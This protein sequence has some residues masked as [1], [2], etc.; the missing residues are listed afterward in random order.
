MGQYPGMK[1][2][3]WYSI[4]VKKTFSIY[5]K[6]IPGINPLADNDVGE[7]QL[8]AFSVG[9]LKTPLDG[10][11]L[12]VHNVGNLS[13]THAVPERKYL[14]PLQMLFLYYLYMMIL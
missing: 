5:F 9:L 1:I 8:L 12:V 13:I 7:L 14:M 10:S 3:E 6:Y 2:L 4:K 11:Y